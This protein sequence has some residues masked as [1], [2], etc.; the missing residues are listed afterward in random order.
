MIVATIKRMCVGIVLYEDAGPVG[1]MW[2]SLLANPYAVCAYTYVCDDKT[3]C[4]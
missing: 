4:L 3:P 2:V 1:G